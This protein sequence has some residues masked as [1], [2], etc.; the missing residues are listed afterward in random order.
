MGP[1]GQPNDPKLCKHD[2]L[3]NNAG[4]SLAAG[5]LET[6]F[7]QRDRI[8]DS[9]KSVFLGMKHATPHM[10]ANNGGSII[11]I[12]SIAGLTGGTA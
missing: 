4:I 9:K 7:E 1:N 5:L 10:Q 8:I 3:I 12:S 6:T 11:N 2:I